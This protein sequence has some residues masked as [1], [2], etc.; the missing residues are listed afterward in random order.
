M[1][2]SKSKTMSVIKKVGKI[3]IGCVFGDAGEVY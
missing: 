2:G 3:W 1:F